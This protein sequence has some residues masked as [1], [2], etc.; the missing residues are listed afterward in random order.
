[1]WRGLS[2]LVLVLGCLLITLGVG[3]GGLVSYLT[4]RE[5]SAPST[6]RV[7]VL[8]DGR[9]IPLVQPTQAA[10]IQIPIATPSAL[11]SP[12]LTLPG[13]DEA[14][15]ATQPAPPAAV[16]TLPGADQ[17]P[18]P[19][20]PAVPLPSPTGVAAARPGLSLAPGTAHAFLPPQRITIPRI[21]VDWPVVLS[22]NEELPHF[23]GVGWLMGSTYPGFA[24]NLVL[25]GHLDGPYAT[26]GR[27]RELV[28]GDTF[29]V[30][31]EDGARVYRVRS[32]FSVTPDDV[33]VLAPTST[34]TATLI[35]CSG[36]WDKVAKQYDHRLII[37]ADYTGP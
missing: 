1:M 27:L 33:S 13:G 37:L 22:V 10:P 36:H 30:I 34:A 7:L 4:W 12:V 11:P 16:P 35:T 9:R 20:M 8:K 3:Y 23:K 25:F 21:G 19:T 15:A 32:S 2:R 29:N 5:S 24:G 17:A 28:P 14:P 18:A 6:S 26:L 31:T